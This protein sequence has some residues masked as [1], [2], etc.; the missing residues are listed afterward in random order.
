[1]LQNKGE[2][3]AISNLTS[4]KIA[5][6]VRKRVRYTQRDYKTLQLVVVVV[7][8]FLTFYCC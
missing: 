8:V 4:K 7:V 2:S 5:V 6:V 1:M 3:G